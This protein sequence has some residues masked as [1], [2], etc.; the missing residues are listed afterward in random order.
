MRKTRICVV[1]LVVALVVLALA[2][3]MADAKKKVIPP[4]ATPFGATYADWSAA[5]WQWVF[6]IPQ[7]KNPCF[8]FTGD[9]AAMG[10]QGKVWFLA[11]TMEQDNAGEMNAERTCTI[12]HGRA[13][14][15]PIINSEMS[16]PEAPDAT[17]SDLIGMVTGFI[18]SVQT[19]ALTV[20]GRDIA[21]T[22][23]FRVNTTPVEA[24]APTYT[25]PAGGVLEAWG[26]APGTYP[27]YGDG[28]YVMLAPLSAGDH[29]IM[30]Q[31]VAGGEGWTFATEVT[32]HLTVK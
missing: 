22:E 14:F 30:I 19:A 28:Y 9:N 16:P 4:S 24:D 7:D 1:V 23:A 13:L 32:Y 27:F 3:P 12:P 2:A 15:I 21:V 26:V 11:G 5:W 18:D 10:Q 25:M 8:D 20:D 29:E 31:G 6:A 17:W